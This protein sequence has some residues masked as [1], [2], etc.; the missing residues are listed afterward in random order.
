MNDNWQRGLILRGARVR[1]EKKISQREMF[2]DNGQLDSK[3]L[4]L[5]AKIN[6]ASHP[7]RKQIKITRNSQLK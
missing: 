4:L 1:D 6:P 7:M 3:C 5:E 2:P